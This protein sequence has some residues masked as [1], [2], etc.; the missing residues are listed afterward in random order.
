[1]VRLGKAIVVE[2]KI[3]RRKLTT[4]Q[5]AWLARLDAAGIEALVWTPD[6]WEEI[7]YVLENA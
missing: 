6:K 2:L 5:M 4:E 1:M 7:E 3:G